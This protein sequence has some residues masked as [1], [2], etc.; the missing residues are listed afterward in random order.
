ML[1]LSEVSLY[2]Y[3]EWSIVM[4]VRFLFDN[5]RHAILLVWNSYSEHYSDTVIQCI[6]VV[7]E[8]RH[9]VDEVELHDTMKACWHQASSFVAISKQKI[10]DVV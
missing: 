6:T 9:M 8:Q 4:C 1:P 10:I 7:A 3:F 2:T 5:F